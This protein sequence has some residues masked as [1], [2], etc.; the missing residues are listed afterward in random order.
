MQPRLNP[1][2]AAPAL[3]KQFLDYS[4]QVGAAGIEPDLLELVKIR[5]SQLNGCANCLNMHSSDA[6][7]AGESEQRLHLLAAW[8]EAPLFSE[9]ERAA[10]AWTDHL[11]LIADRRA[12]D[13]IYAALDA[14]FSK[15]EQ[16]K[17]TMMINAI[18]GWNRLAIGFNLYDARLGW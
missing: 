10:L 8:Q 2:A 17:L 14:E 6:R 3:M 18:N 15:E 7:K 9:R 13:D 16:I 11:T 12:P 4:T 5:A 1:F